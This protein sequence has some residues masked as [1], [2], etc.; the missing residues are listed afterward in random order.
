MKMKEQERLARKLEEIREELESLN[1]RMEAIIDLQRDDRKVRVHT[2][3]GI[4]LDAMTLLS[5]PDHLRQTFMTVCR[6][7]HATAEE[8]A[9][10]MNRARAAESGNLNQLVNMGF[11]KK[12]KKGRKT[13]F[14]I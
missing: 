8:I 5:M 1:D 7:N 12:E 2:L 14:F 9:Q 4:P 10:Q 6:F 13:Y 3:P 11:L